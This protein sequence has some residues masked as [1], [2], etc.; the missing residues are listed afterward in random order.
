MA[1]CL[2]IEDGLD[3]EPHLA[4]VGVVEVAD[5]LDLLLEPPVVLLL[6]LAPDLLLVLH[7]LGGGDGLPVQALQP[8]DEAAPHQKYQNGHNYHEHPP[9]LLMVD[10]DSPVVNQGL[11]QGRLGRLQVGKGSEMSSLLHYK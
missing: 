5:V 11:N 8:L 9:R 7:L 10:A 6:D 3:G 2:V 4:L 1:T